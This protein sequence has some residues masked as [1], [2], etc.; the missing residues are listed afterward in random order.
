VTAA[1][2]AIGRRAAVAVLLSLGVLAAP[3]V[4]GAQPAGRVRR[5]GIILEPANEPFLRSF[6]QGLKELGY[7]EGKDIAIEYRHVGTALDRVPDLAGEL[8]RLGVDVLVVPGTVAAR[9]AKNAAT[10]V[11]IRLPAIYNRREFAEAGGLMADGQLGRL[12]AL[13]DLV[14]VRCRAPI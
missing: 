2:P 13:E 6:Q 5:I 1:P 11:P 7:A 8:V 9:L 4:A 14:D 3:P 12:R 10:S